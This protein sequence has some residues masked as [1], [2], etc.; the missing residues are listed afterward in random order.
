VAIRLIGIDIDGTLLDSRS[1]IPQANQQAIAAAFARGIEIALVTG[2]RFDFALPIARRIP[3]PLTMVVNNGALIRAKSGETFHRQML[4]R[5]AAR[6]VLAATREYRSGT[7]VIFDRP[8]ENQIIFETLDLTNNSR[9]DYWERNRE[10]IGE[11]TPLESCLTEDP[12][13]VMFTGGVGPMREV[14]ARLRALDGAQD[15]GGKDGAAAREISVAVT[16]YEARDF[17]LVDVL[18]AHVSKGHAL[19]TWARMR[20]YRREEVMAVGDNLN[21]AEMLEYAGVAVVM[22]NSVEELKRDGWFVTGTNDEA[23]VASA[24]ERYAL[25]DRRS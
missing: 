25:G 1:Q 23:G 7:T 13:Q 17:S 21:D 2:R 12:I 16:E 18:H 9:R 19:A 14:A 22:G 3:C 5:E 24:I 20:G 4:D 8:R 6:R 10:F 11:A 15:G